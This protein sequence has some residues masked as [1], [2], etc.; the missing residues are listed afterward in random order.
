LYRGESFTAG[1]R[2][3]MGIVELAEFLPEFKKWEMQTD[4]LEEGEL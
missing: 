3:C 4:E 2:S 1:A